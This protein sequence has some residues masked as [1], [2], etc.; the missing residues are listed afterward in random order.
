MKIGNHEVLSFHT[1]RQTGMRTALLHNGDE[2]VTAVIP[3]SFGPDPSEWWQ[4]N[5]H[6]ESY[7]TARQDFL[8]WSGLAAVPEE[9]VMRAQSL[10]DEW[11]ADADPRTEYAERDQEDE[12]AATNSFED[13][14]IALLYDLAAATKSTAVKRS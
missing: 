4:G 5:Y 7:D 6:G 3:K 12:E 10:L 13:R 8:E 9:F 11:E 2:W 1:I 14:A